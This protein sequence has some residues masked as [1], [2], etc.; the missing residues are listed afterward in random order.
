MRKA[1]SRKNHKE[2]CINIVPWKKRILL[3]N[4][5]RDGAG[6][7]KVDG[8]SRRMKRSKKLRKKSI[9]E[10]RKGGRVR[11]PETLRGLSNRFVENCKHFG[12]GWCWIGRD[13]FITD[14]VNAKFHSAN[15]DHGF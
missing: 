14:S 3:I 1:R 13:D 6:R 12:N 9:F 10:S 8:D 5:V 15:L 7:A 2:K 4:G 11:S